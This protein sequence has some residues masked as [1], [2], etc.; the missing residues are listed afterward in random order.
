MKDKNR[1][2]AG[3][4]GNLRRLAKIGELRSRISCYEKAARRISRENAEI[5]PIE[6][7]R[8]ELGRLN[9]I[10]T[11]YR[12]LS[13]KLKLRLDCLQFFYLEQRFKYYGLLLLIKMARSKHLLSSNSKQIKLLLTSKRDPTRKRLPKSGPRPPSEDQPLSHKK[14]QE[15]I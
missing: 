10:R 2:K 5:E 11:K 4:K 15:N 14:E 9:S 1:I 7:F 8:G 6:Y 13:L 3:E 12:F